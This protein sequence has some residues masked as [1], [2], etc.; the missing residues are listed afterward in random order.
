MRPTSPTAGVGLLALAGLALPLTLDCYADPS[1]SSATVPPAERVFVATDGEVAPARDPAQIQQSE[2]EPAAPADKLVHIGPAFTMPSLPLGDDLRSLLQDRNYGTAAARV[3]AMDRATLDPSVQPDHAF[4]L[5]WLR[6]HQGQADQAIP[7]LEQLSGDGAAPAAYLSLVSGELLL[8][9]D[10]PAEAVEVL[11]AVVPGSAAIWPRAQV[12]LAEAYY[13]LERTAD[14]RAT[15]QA[16]ILREDPADGTALALLTTAKRYGL[17]SEDAYPLLRRIWRAYPRSA[18]DAEAS[19]ALAAYEARG[20]TFRPSLADKAA[21]G[22]ALMDQNR[23]GDAITLLAPV[24]ASLKEASP[25]ACRAWYVYGRS[26]YRTNNL[27]EAHAVLAPAGAACAEHDQDRGAK[28][29]YLAGK[30]MERKKEWGEAALVYERI[31]ELYPEHSMADDGYALAGI[32]YQEAGDSDTATARWASQVQAYP[33]GDM[34]GEGFWR[35]AWTAYLAGDTDTAIAWVDQAAETLTVLQDPVHF[36][37]AR[38]WRQRWRLYPD[39]ANPSALV[40]DPVQREAAIEGL[41]ELCRAH[42]ASYYGLLAAARLQELAPE[43][44][45][46][47]PHPALGEA[48]GAWQVRQSFLETPAASNALALARVGLVSE[49]VTELNQLVE[50]EMI[51]GEIGV[52]TDLM[53]ASGQWL[54]AHDRLRRYLDVHPP[55]TLEHNRARL[56]TSAYM[57]RYE[58]EVKAACAGYPWDYRLFH[59]LVREESNFNKDIVSHAGARGLSQL[60]PAT[61]RSVARWL[62]TTVSDSGMFVPETNL[63]IGGRYLHFLMGRYQGDPFI[64]LA[65]YNAGEGNVDKWLRERGN[66]PVDEF[67]EGIPFRETRHYVKRVSASWQ[68]YHLLY[69]GGDAF[70]AL[71]AF[72]HQAVPD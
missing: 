56:L 71:A 55:E 54:W 19:K 9:D 64:S 40:E 15:Y 59:A 43:R 6:V 46:A 68:M 18:E 17:G 58:A 13:S 21:R 36:R 11:G 57:R 51:P 31:P 61:A 4:L 30:A 47:L 34:A 20:T 16:L 45:A 52:F 23:F 14:S 8:A 22:E 66:R 35:L 37:A 65:G 28:A 12:Q 50:A 41:L 62:G 2:P 42:P 7:L 3:A 26:K 60:M 29:L 49:A 32:G 27:T 69:D 70:P 67:V 72:N 1:S 63:R 33:D 39:Y 44:L 48:P 53:V 25:E 10:R 38:Y 5:A 24:V